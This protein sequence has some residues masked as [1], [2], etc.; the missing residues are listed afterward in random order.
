MKY[1]IRR[2]EMKPKII[3]F[4]I[5][6][7]V[8]ALT[9]CAVFQPTS[10]RS[11]GVIMSATAAPGAPLPA[12]APNAGELVSKDLSTQ[13]Q[14]TDQI[15]IKNASLSIAVLDPLTSMQTIMSMAND[16]GG[17]VVSS[18]VYKTTTADNVEVPVVD[19]SVRVP[20]EKLDQAMQQ[21][22]SL[23]PDVKTDVL[24]ENIS[25]QDVT[26]D[27]TD[28]ESRLNNLKAAEAQLVKIMDQATR[29]EDVMAVFNQLTSVRE[30]IEVL[31]GQLNY[32][33]ES[34]QLSAL[35]VHIQ[36]KEALKPI[37]IGGWQPGLE[38]Q[39]A[40]QA[41]VDG[42]KMLV[43]LLI[44]LIIVL[45]PILLLIGVPIF[46]IVRFIRNRRQTTKPVVVKP[47]E[48]KK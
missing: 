11:S 9:S 43:S 40:L 4:L 22:K 30:Q 46:L 27:Y 35:S 2:S 34:S 23:V 13:T 15:V 39:K 18:N 28:T 21:I 42:L 1:L 44:W 16:M 20:A 47:P 10:E 8:L 31:Q 19:V 29:T 17:Y 45:V 6:M 26:K 24:L 41:L 5:A 14:S 37:T 25:G 3:L 12:M 33:K 48:S 38:V 7:N 36:A 32:Y